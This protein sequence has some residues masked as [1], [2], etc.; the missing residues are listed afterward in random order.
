VGVADD[1]DAGDDEDGEAERALALA[2][3]LVVG[4]GPITCSSGRFCG[5]EREW[6]RVAS[7]RN[8]AGMNEQFYSP[9]RDRLSWARTSA[10]QLFYL[11]VRDRLRTVSTG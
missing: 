11:P 4:A 1:V 5:N 10:R 8:N 7:A 3:D 9:V 6:E 2:A